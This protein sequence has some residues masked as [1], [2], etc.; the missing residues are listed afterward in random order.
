VKLFSEREV[1]NTRVKIS[2]LEA[3]YEI[4]QASRGDLNPIAHR[5]MLATL[6]RRINRMKEDIVRYQSRAQ[7]AQ[8]QPTSSH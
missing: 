6:R 1:E 3:T 4:A 2:E 7:L 5:L 8:K